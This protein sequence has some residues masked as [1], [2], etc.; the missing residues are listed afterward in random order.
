M[1][2]TPAMTITTAGLAPATSRSKR[3][4][5]SS[6]RWPFTP[7]LRTSHSGCARISQYAYWLRSSPLPVGGSSI[8]LRNAGVPAVVL[9]PSATMVMRSVMAGV[10]GGEQRAAA[11]RRRRRAL[12]T[13]P[14]PAHSL[15]KQH[16]RRAA[17]ALELL[18]RLLHLT[19]HP[20]H[21]AAKDLPDV[22]VGVAAAQELRR[23]DW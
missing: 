5:I 15:L 22:V 13:S 9:S 21:V 10:A 17:L 8:G 12:R 19:H 14:A 20:Q 16:G 3:I 2:F 4:A 11:R 18:R 6:V 1:S 23:E 7:R